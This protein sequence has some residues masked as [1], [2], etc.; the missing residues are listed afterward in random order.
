MAL[1]TEWLSWSVRSGGTGWG[2]SPRLNC[3]AE[4]SGYRRVMER[5]ESWVPGLEEWVE[6]MVWSKMTLWEASEGCCGSHLQLLNI[7]QPSHSWR[8]NTE[9]CL[10]KENIFKNSCFQVNGDVFQDNIPLLQVSKQGQEWG[11]RNYIL[12]FIYRSSGTCPCQ[13]S[14]GRTLSHNTEETE[15]HH[16]CSRF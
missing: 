9:P 13:S 2:M 14:P 15:Q 3:S 16:L 4:A 11:F 7:S 10:E 5:L 6:M 12:L 1:V 8:E